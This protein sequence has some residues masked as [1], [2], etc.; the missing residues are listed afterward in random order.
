MTL[1]DCNIVAD[2]IFE[3][4]GDLHDN[5]KLTGF[6]LG[7]KLKKSEKLLS[8]IE[9]GDLHEIFKLTD[10][11]L[12]FTFKKG[13]LIPSKSAPLLGFTTV[14]FS[15]LLWLLRLMVSQGYS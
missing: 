4:G 7:F 3:K 1:L 2:A 9:G 6:S 8:T 13:A 5:V 14:T 12:N 11:S 10:F 15:S